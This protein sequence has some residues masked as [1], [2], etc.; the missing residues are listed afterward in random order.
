MKRAGPSLESAELQGALLNR[1]G[2]SLPIVFPIAIS[3]KILASQCKLT[4]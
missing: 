3:G 4:Y 2:R 1:C